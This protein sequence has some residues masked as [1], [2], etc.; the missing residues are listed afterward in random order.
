METPDS[1]RARDYMGYT[2]VIYWGNHRRK[3]KP[4]TTQHNAT[5]QNRIEQN[6]IEQN[7]YYTCR[8]EIKYRFAQN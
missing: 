1:L 2:I 4:I 5:Q 3:K 7:T 6:R 8:L